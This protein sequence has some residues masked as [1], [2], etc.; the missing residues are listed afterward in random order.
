[1]SNSVGNAISFAHALTKHLLHI[2]EHDAQH[3]FIGVV[4]RGDSWTVRVSYS[5]FLLEETAPTLDDA[6]EA[7]VGSLTA[8]VS[9]QLEEGAKLLGKNET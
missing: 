8:S 2:P 5:G 6:M 1:M 3:V 7:V 9:T 4:P